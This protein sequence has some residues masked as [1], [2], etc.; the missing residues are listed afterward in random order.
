MDSSAIGLQLEHS[1]FKSFLC[2]GLTFAVFKGVGYIPEEKER[3]KIS[4]SCVEISFF[5]NFNVLVSILFV[6]EDLLSLREDII[7]I[8][9]SLSV[10][11]MKKEFKS[12]PFSSV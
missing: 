9:S 10:D 11:V 2:M 8:T 4:T 6:P 5:S 12:S 3:L 7:E 1:R